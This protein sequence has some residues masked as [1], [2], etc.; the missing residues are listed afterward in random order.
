MVIR[1]VFLWRSC[2]SFAVLNEVNGSCFILQVDVK[3]GEIGDRKFIVK[4]RSDTGSNPTLEIIKKFKVRNMTTEK[5]SPGK[6]L[7]DKITFTD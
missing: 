1:K 5:Y 7:V 3:A 6:E 2:D 4:S